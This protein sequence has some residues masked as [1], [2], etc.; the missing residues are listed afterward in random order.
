[1]IILKILLLKRYIVKLFSKLFYVKKVSLGSGPE[2]GQLA[3]KSQMSH[4]EWGL[5]MGQ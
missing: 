4:K 3:L 5:H 2:F 1:M